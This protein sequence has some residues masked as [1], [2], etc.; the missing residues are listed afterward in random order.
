[1]AKQNVDTIIDDLGQPAWKKVFKEVIEL[2]RYMQLGLDAGALTR[3][4]FDI[5]LVSPTAW[6]KAA[7]RGFGAAI[8]NPAKVAR[9]EEEFMRDPEVLKAIANGLAIDGP[10][11]MPEGFISKAA[12]KVPGYGRGERFHKTFQNFARYETYR[13]LTRGQ[14][15]NQYQLKETAKLINA[16]TGRGGW[17]GA[18]GKLA[19]IYTAPKMYAGQLEVMAKTATAIVD[20]RFRTNPAYRKLI[21]RRWLGRMGGIVALKALAD[22]TDWEFSINPDDSDFLKLRNGNTVIDVTGGYSSWY[23]LLF[24]TL[25][26]IVELGMS[27]PFVE[28]LQRSLGYKISPTYR[29]PLSLITGKDAIG[30]PFFRNPDTNEREVNVNDLAKTFA[31]LIGMQIYEM[32]GGDEGYADMDNPAKVALGGLGF[33]GTGVSNYEPRDPSRKPEDTKWGQFLESAGIQPR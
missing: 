19:S 5:A 8:S 18:E 30:K 16:M 3:Q 9:L 7:K 32:A 27:E 12:Q 29:L 15:M 1:V 22:A 25:N 20:P 24:S 4:G 21:V 2:P 23:K 14:N 26:D 11:D 28:R 17:K 6:T 33:I 31:P 13:N 10:S